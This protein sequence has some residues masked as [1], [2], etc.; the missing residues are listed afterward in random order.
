M[1]LPPILSEF[2]AHKLIAERI[3]DAL[4][5]DDRVLGIYLSGSF[6]HGKPDV[7]SDLDF[8][9]LVAAD[10]RDLLKTDH[11]RLRQQVGD[12]LSEFPATHLG[13]PNQFIVFYRAEFPVHVDYQYRIPDDLVP[14]SRDGNVIVLLDRSGV[15]AS[16]KARC[17]AIEEFNGPTGEQ[18]QYF[19]D[20]FWA[21]C[22]Y[23]AGKIRRGE[24]WEARD[25]VEYLRNNVLI[26]IV[27]Y[28]CDLS[29][30][31]NRRLETKFPPDI[32]KSLEKTVQHNHSQKEYR[33]TLLAIAHCY[34]D[35]MDLSAAKFGIHIDRKDRAYFIQLLS[36]Y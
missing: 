20:R 19:E 34:T 12:V 22:V 10:V 33:A 9:I 13:D 18:L 26:R 24:L 4:L 36:I 5:H 7:Y 21:W 1:E 8:N 30:E 23:T 25:A 16:W 3:A 17:A 15:L 27:Y 31:G 32:L 11:A 14:R 35:F 2:P 29:P 28:L 6:A